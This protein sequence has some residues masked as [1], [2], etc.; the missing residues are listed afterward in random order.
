DLPEYY[1][2]RAEL[3]IL[4][5]DA[6]AM[7]ACLRPDCLVIEYGSGS[8]VKTRL[9]LEALQR[10]AGY[11]PVEIAR[12]CLE[13]TAATLAARFPGLP[14]RPVCTDF[15]RPIQLP[16]GLPASARRAVYFPGSTIGNFGPAGA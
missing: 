5:A 7:A 11:L 10:P 16:A 15:T 6:P 14:V 3:E 4:R 2:T 13:Q 1:P 12:E 9:L 8:G